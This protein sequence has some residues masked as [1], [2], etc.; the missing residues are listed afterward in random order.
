MATTLT[1]SDNLTIR[2]VD[3]KPLEQTFFSKN[4]AIELAPGLHTLV[5][6]YKDVFEDLEFADERLVKSDYFVVKFTVDSQKSLFLTTIE[7]GDLAEAER[8]VKSPELKMLAGDKVELFL[9]L[10]TLNDY[11]L[12]KQVS[13]VITTIGSSNA[14]MTQESSLNGSDTQTTEEINNFN[15]KVLEEVDAVPMLKYWWGKSTKEQ[16][17]SFLSFIESNKQQGKSP[18]GK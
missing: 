1:Y 7:I 12:G 17:E 6:K 3:D 16:K 11:N 13:Q 4:T 18:V 15:Q 8:F 10:E 5:V 9:V 14:D 2:D